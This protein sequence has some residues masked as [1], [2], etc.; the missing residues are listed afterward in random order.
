MSRR[1]V[2]SISSLNRGISEA[3]LGIDNR[4]GS[5][6]TFL[7]LMEDGWSRMIGA[8]LFRIGEL[9]ATAFVS[10]LL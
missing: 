8:R 6:D 10:T 3:H 2:Y 4:N 1:V 7:P 9:L 5:A